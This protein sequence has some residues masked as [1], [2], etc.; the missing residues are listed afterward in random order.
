MT[1]DAG[2]HPEAK[3][4]LALYDGIELVAIKF[5][6]F[7]DGANDGTQPAAELAFTSD[8]IKSANVI[9]PKLKAFLWSAD[10]NKPLCTHVLIPTVE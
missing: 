10:S 1:K 9:S 6:G 7:A 5:A 2:T 8:E 4:Y 3:A